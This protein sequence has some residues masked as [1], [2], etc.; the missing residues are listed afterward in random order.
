ME[1]HDHLHAIKHL[2]SEEL[3]N[4][5]GGAISITGTLVNGITNGFRMI[6][7]IGKSLG[8][9]IIRIKEDTL[10]KIE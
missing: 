5:N 8:S 1:S 6:H 3:L 2:S 10:C 9:S 7:E 4:I